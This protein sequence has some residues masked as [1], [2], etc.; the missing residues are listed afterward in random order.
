MRKRREKTP[1][2]YPNIRPPS[3]DSSSSEEEGK[4]SAAAAAAPEDTGDGRLCR[5]AAAGT[6][7]YRE[8]SDDDDDDDEDE[9]ELPKKRRNESFRNEIDDED[10][11]SVY[12]QGE[13]EATIAFCCAVCSCTQAEK[14]SVC[15]QSQEYCSMQ[16]G[17]ATHRKCCH[18]ART[19]DEN[20]MTGYL[21][22][23]LNV[24]E[25][26][27]EKKIFTLKDFDGKWRTAKKQE[28]EAH[29]ED[30]EIVLNDLY[31]TSADYKDKI[32]RPFKEE[33]PRGK[34]IVLD[35]FAG[36][37]A[38]LVCLKR[39]GIAI[40]KVIVVEHDPVSMFVYKANHDKQFVQEITDKDEEIGSGRKLINE[41][42]MEDD[43]VEEFV[44]IKK[45]E[46]LL[47][48]DVKA[49]IR[50]HGG[51]AYFPLFSFY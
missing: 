45:F 24:E 44:Y 16:E 12:S 8:S 27:E 29:N 4:V 5:R 19:V 14:Q 25:A 10:S 38:G 48:Y 9:D 37:G 43:C 47:K 20:W 3:D 7:H 28:A 15:L 39:L 22:A 26:P 1:R 13:N 34:A 41:T 2:N 50:E 51:K 17:G 23:V 11:I 40:K 49:F 32:E 21:A 33:G 31:Q 46:E 42:I 30:A 18:R 6:K 36:I 35:C